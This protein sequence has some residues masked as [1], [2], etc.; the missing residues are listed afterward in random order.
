MKTAPL[1]LSSLNRAIA[2]L[3]AGRAQAETLR[4]ESAHIQ[5]AIFSIETALGLL[6]AAAFEAA[7]Q[8]RREAWQPAAA[9]AAPG[10]PPLDGSAPGASATNAP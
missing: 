9:P 1:I 7:D 10:T 3:E 8:V 6:R 4:D 2:H 5:P